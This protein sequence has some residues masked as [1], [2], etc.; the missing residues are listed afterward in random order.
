VYPITIDY[1]AAATQ[2]AGI[3]RLVRE[4]V[5][6]LIGHDPVTPFRLVYPRGAPHP[7][8]FTQANV[9]TVTLPLSA[10][11]QQRVWHRLRIPLP[12]EWLVG[13]YALYHA[14]DFLLPHT[15]SKAPTILTVH[16]L[17]FERVPDA[18]SPRLRAFLQ[19][20][21]PRSVRRAT[22]IIADSEATRQDLIELYR[23]PPEKVSVVL[24]SVAPRF[25]PTQDN[26]VRTKY[27]IGEHPFFLCIGTVQPRK[28]YPRVVRA[29]A[30]LG[31]EWNHVHLV[32]AG[33][34]GWL[35]DELYATIASANMAQRVHL[36]GFADDHDLPAL[37]SAAKC[38]IAA[39]LYE[40]F[41]FPVLES[42]ACGTPVI[43][44]AVSSLPEVAGDA[45]LLVDPYDV[46]ALAAAM[47]RILSDTALAEEL[48]QRGREQAARFTP[49]ATARQLA[50]VY[51]K[52]LSM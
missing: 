17:S 14:T 29:L 30:A 31:P 46:E 45:A 4:Q 25:K 20:A 11:W 34:K 38:T 10:I 19:A 22:H 42:M 50:D 27:E 41:G 24:S 21:V 47:R 39:S 32:I 43:T 8:H 3:G 35:E 23:C 40:G 1:T 16:D 33:G 28:N 52:V 36:I 26:A 48:R 2:T 6:A 44:S 7:P 15:S 37:Y 12:I 18:A 9:Q 49:Q 13:R 51:S 5:E